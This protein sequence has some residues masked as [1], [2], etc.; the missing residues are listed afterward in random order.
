[1]TVDI[2]NAF[3]Q[4]KME[5]KESEDK[6]IMKITGVM[7]DM[8]VQMSPEVYGPKVVYQKG[9]KILYVEVLR[10]IYGMLQSALLFH[11]KI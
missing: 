4:T 3:I 6:I 9:K 5:R 8:L 2:P 11:K 7:V 1:M 10:A